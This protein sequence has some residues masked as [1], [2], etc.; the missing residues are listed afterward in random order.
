MSQEMVIQSCC[1][2]VYIDPDDTTIDRSWSVW[3]FSTRGEI[4]IMYLGLVLWWNG[5][6]WTGGWPPKRS[7][8]IYCNCNLFSFSSSNYYCRIQGLSTQLQLL[9][10]HCVENH[11]ITALLDTRRKNE[12]ETTLPLS[13]NK[14]QALL[15]GLV[16]GRKGCIES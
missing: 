4:D 11:V 7:P 10:F 13:G 1:C 6:C 5:L 3:K 2:S 14:A 9:L 15:G 16:S 12:L 8:R